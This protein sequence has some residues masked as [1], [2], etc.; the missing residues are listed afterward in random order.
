MLANVAHPPFPITK[1]H[2]FVADGGGPWKYQQV[3]K[4]GVTLRSLVDNVKQEWE[5]AMNTQK[6]ATTQANQTNEKKA[7]AALQTLHDTQAEATRGA[8][9]AKAKAV[10][11]KNKQRKLVSYVRDRGAPPAKVSSSQ[12]ARASR[13][14]GKATRGAPSKKA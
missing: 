2:T 3:G 7:A 4:K 11:E 6:T 13:S 1:C 8:A 10:L 12:S 14:A 9:R 5:A